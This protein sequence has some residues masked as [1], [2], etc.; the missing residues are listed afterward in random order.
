MIL[1]AV[2]CPA[3]RGAFLMLVLGR[4]VGEAVCVIVRGRQGPEVL[5]VKLLRVQGERI[6]L[7]FEG[8]DS[9]VIEREELAERRAEGGAA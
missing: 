7:G 9:F 2:F 5:R 3:T 6:R 1:V 4:Q 8:P